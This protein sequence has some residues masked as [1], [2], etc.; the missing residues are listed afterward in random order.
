MKISYHLLIYKKTNF[1]QFFKLD[2]RLYQWTQPDVALKQISHLVK[3]KIS[4]GTR[5]IIFS[6]LDALPAFATTMFMD[7]FTTTNPNFKQSYFIFTVQVAMIFKM[8]FLF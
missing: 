6:R 3:N 7:I 8:Q 5:T 1:L 2:C 4:E